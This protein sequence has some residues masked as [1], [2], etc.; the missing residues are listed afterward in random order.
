MAPELTYLPPE[1][2][3]PCDSMT[4]YHLMIKT[5]PVWTSFLGSHIKDRIRPKPDSHEMGFYS[6]C[7]VLVHQV[8]MHVCCVCILK[9]T[10]KERSFAQ[11]AAFNGL[12]WRFGNGVARP[13][14]ALSGLTCRVV[15]YCSVICRPGHPHE[16]SGRRPQQ[17]L[18][19]PILGT[20]PTKTEHQG[21]P[22]KAPYGSFP[23]Y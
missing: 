10:D 15:L 2:L 1:S 9:A 3:A 21:H 18:M 14:D 16:L 12:R 17:H 8:R 4:K 5:G 22:T 6:A 11:K 23:P 19:I 7:A 20:A 13:S